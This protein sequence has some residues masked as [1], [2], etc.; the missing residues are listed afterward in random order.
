[1]MMYD[2]KSNDSRISLHRVS[3]REGHVLHGW[4]HAHWISG[5]FLTLFD[6]WLTS[7][8]SRNLDYLNKGVDV[9]SVSTQFREISLT[10]LGECGVD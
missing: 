4:E 8:Q 10:S 2:E 1:M 5:E 6:Y 3:K 7:T 9:F